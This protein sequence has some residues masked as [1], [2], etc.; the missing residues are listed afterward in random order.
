MAI[1]VQPREIDVPQDDPFQNDLLERKES[2]EVLTRLI[3]AFEGP[4]VLAVDAAWGYGKTTFLNMW[5][6]HLLKQEFP[7]VKFNAWETDFS[8]E[9]FVT[10]SA[11]LTKGLQEYATDSLKQKIDK[12][13]EA[14]T[15]IIRRAV[16]GLVRVAT[17]GLLDIAPLL[18]EEMAQSL[19]SYTED[20]LSAYEETQ[21]SVKEFRVVL[22]DMAKTL[23]E[24][25]G[26]PLIIMID[27]LDRCRP[28]YAV[29]LLEV[30][31]HLFSV[32][33]VVFV[34][35]I[36]RN[37]LGHSIKALYGGE[38]DAE[39]YLRRFFDIDFQLPEP[40]REKF[41]SAL[42]EAV[43]VPDYF[44]RTQNRDEW[45]YE[46]AL[47]FL[48]IFLGTSDIS[49]RRIAQ[50]I[51]RLGL[52]LASLHDRYLKLAAVA[53]VALILR[54]VNLNLYHRF[55][56]GEVTDEEVVNAMFSR[57]E[58][59]DIRWENR[60]ALFEA[61]VIKA[62]RE[63]SGQ[64]SADRINSPL[65]DRY[66]KQIDDEEMD[67]KDHT[68]NRPDLKHAKDVVDLAVRL[69]RYSYGIGFQHSI[70]CLELLSGDLVEK[71]PEQ[72]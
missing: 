29:E 72:V 22:E 15:E 36:N 61:I 43:G 23:S 69:S 42:L 63:M 59:K 14:A 66:Q 18:K 60:S 4:C 54:T 13:K 27:E 6:Q 48:Q 40:K 34:L 45:N 11:E 25:R 55:I 19:A 70:Q 51:H 37:Q 9:P 10:L 20:R 26:H 68:K 31:K 58:T 57:P 46:D 44:C 21:E 12:T 41:I 65:L 64:Y 71:S 62:A 56:R 32:D 24:E 47:T 2:A 7:V 38:F 17:M 30:A 5:T 1:R 53:I 50:S 33:H 49:L 28:S 52:V 16:P 3:D 39:D 67:G 8:D 35:A